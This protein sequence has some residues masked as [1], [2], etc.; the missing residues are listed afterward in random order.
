M[1]NVIVVNETGNWGRTKV[2]RRQLRHELKNKAVFRPENV[3]NITLSAKNRPIFNIHPQWSSVYRGPTPAH[4]P[5]L[6]GES[7]RLGILVH[8]TD[9]QLE[10][11]Y[12]RKSIVGKLDK[13]IDKAI[14][15]T[16]FRKGESDHDGQSR[17]CA[18]QGC[19]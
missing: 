17:G 5:Q 7:R 15:R 16:G 13:G 2:E 19:D 4:Q 11:A 8:H 1:S 14:A 3:L 18:S 12:D 6:D 9:A 10:F